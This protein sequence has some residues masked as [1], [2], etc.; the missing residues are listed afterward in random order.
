MSEGY[1]IVGVYDENGDLLT[2][3]SCHLTFVNNESKIVAFDVVELGSPE[4]MF[5]SNIQVEGGHVG[6][7]ENLDIEILGSRMY[8]DPGF[9]L[10]FMRGDVNTDGRVD[11]SDAIMTLSS[12]VM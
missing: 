2:T 5:L 12:V 3:D 6:T 1:D 8:P 7:Q 9:V 10:N 4:P 11:I